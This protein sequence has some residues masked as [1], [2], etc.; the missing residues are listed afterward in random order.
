MD[1]Q[2]VYLKDYQKP[3]HQIESVE[4]TFDL[5][6]ER[7]R[8]YSK[9]IVVKNGDSNTLKLDGEDLTFVSL[10]VDGEEVKYQLTD[11][12]LE[13]DVGERSI[14]EVENEINP[15]E[16]TQLMGLY[17]T[18]GIFC[19]HNEP[20][21][22][23]RITYFLDRPDVMAKYKVKIIADK[24]FKC[25][26]SNGNKIA[27]GEEGDRHWAEWE[28]PFPKP[29]YLFAMVA[30]DLGMIEDHF[31][32]MNGRE[33]LLEIYCEKG[34]EDRLK[35]SM[36]SL[37]ESMKW[38]E[39]RFG[40][41]YDLDR[42]MIV[43]VSSFNAGAMENKGLNIF[44]TIALLAD[45]DIS[46]DANLTYV[47][48][49]VGHE[50]FHNWTGD[51]VTLRDWFQLTLKEGLTVF[52]DKEFTSDLNLRSVKRIEDVSALRTVQFAEAAGPMAHPIQPDSFI[53]ID[54][55]YTSTVYEKG[56]EVIGMIFTL[57]GKEC[58]RLGMDK[59]FELY[60]GQAVTTN[61]FVHAMELVS[62]RDLTQFKKWYK[63]VETPVVKCEWNQG[64]LTVKQGDDPL[65]FPL[66]VNGQVFEVKESEESFPIDGSKPPSI[67]QGFSA[68]IIVD[69]DYTMEERMHLMLHDEDSFN[70]WDA[71]QELA[72]QLML[73]HAV[74]DEYVAAFG[75]LLATRPLGHLLALPSEEILAQ[76]QDVID[77]T[78]NFNTREAY[79]RAIGQKYEKELLDYY[80]EYDEAYV[81]EPEAVKRRSFKNAC[82]NIL[83][84][85]GH[86]DL[87]LKQYMEADNMTDRFAALSCLSKQESPESAQAM[88][89]Y[90]NRFKG[91]D[92]PMLKYFAV[93]ASSPVDGALDRIKEVMKLP[94]FDIE[95]PNH[96]RTLFGA[97]TRNLNQ[98]HTADGYAFIADRIIE[99]DGINSH[100]AA[101][102]CTA[103]RK[104]KYLD[105][106]RKALMKKEM[107]R[108]L[109]VKGLSANVYE[110]VSKSL[111]A[112]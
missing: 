45:K 104:F 58:F 78:D 83:A 91:D 87:L 7:T 92:L 105:A 95:V 80:H 94:E 52:R 73:T 65:H 62:K 53:E 26:L 75:E 60:D 32:T 63:N 61:E 22:F 74:D 48:R 51:R 89:D 59:Y 24:Q 90:Y 12:G 98:F 39:E 112:G 10:H 49:V 25:L 33:V 15:R 97:F 3:S 44:N 100:V 17:M 93:I 69:A 99:I 71:G 50:Y 101:R 86:S 54:N 96:S 11:D 21:G 64:L 55:F 36:E 42:F 37:K 28:D 2:P 107:E 29:S 84:R 27:E 66:R 40:R 77:F 67:N 1:H 46:T 106:D 76:R 8:V 79:I 18:D 16:N 82:L 38:D 57:L 47:Q 85:I 5:S 111:A 56:A 72:T 19:S 6:E 35:W 31:V 109:K 13:F 9:M 43:A 110:V 4:L 23:R 68:P 88:A 30:G 103:F 81:F 102:L 34:N 20:Q 108:I 70:Q 41:E 14:V